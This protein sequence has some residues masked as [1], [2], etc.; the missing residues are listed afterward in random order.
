MIY[1]INKYENPDIYGTQT[2]EISVSVTLPPV[3]SDQIMIFRLEVLSFSTST[4]GHQEMKILVKKNFNYNN[5]ADILNINDGGIANL[6]LAFESL[7]P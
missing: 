2:I 5:I 3:N 7:S 1:V 6:A 4:I